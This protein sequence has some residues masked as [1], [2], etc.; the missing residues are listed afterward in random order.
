VSFLVIF[1]LSSLA[2]PG[3]NSFV[4]ELLV[5]VACFTKYKIVGG[6][7]VVG[8]ILAAAYMLRLVQKMV[9]ADSD[10]HVH[11]GARSELFDLNFRETATLTFLTVFVFWIGFHPTPLLDVMDASTAHLVKQVESGMHTSP[12]AHHAVLNE[13]GEMVKNLVAFRH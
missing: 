6:F 5:L 7:A 8:A 12:A 11:P 9:W 10:G 1:S 3:T 4:G 2:F 13:L